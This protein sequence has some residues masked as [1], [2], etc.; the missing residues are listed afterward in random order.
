[1]IIKTKFTLVC[2]QNWSVHLEWYLECGAF[3][4]WEQKM[5]LN[6]TRDTKMRFNFYSDLSPPR[7]FKVSTACLY[8]TVAC[9][10]LEMSE[11]KMLLLH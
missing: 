10:A 8:S 1:M 11:S 2:L 3:I 7:I 9:R 4:A 5:W 6:E